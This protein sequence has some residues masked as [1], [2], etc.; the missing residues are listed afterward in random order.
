VSL[1]GRKDRSDKYPSS[2]SVWG[3]TATPDAAFQW[4]NGNTYFFRYIFVEC[5]MKHLFARYC[6]K[7]NY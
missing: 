2:I 5:I 4:D 7:K 3:L 1:D 6:T